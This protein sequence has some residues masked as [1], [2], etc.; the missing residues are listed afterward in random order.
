MTDGPVSPLDDHEGLLPG[1]PEIGAT[2]R[3]AFLRHWYEMEDALNRDGAVV[4]EHPEHFAGIDVKA[5]RP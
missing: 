1:N 5:V 3:D 2:A 4:R